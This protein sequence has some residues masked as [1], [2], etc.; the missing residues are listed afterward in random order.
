M[1]V[2][3]TRPTKAVFRMREACE[4]LGLCRNTVNKYSNLGMIQYKRRGKH[5]VFN[6]EDLDKYRDSDSQL[7]GERPVGK[8]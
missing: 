6:I 2:L 7:N 1:E 8:E 5:R 3:V 4:Y